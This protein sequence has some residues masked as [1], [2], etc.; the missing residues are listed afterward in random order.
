MGSVHGNVLV[1]LENEFQLAQQSQED[2]PDVPSYTTRSLNYGQL[3][4]IKGMTDLEFEWNHVPTLFVIDID[5][6]GRFSLE[7][8]KSFA[9][10]V[11]GKVPKHVP[12]DDFVGEVQA[13]CCFRMWSMCKET[14]D[15]AGAFTQWLSRLL[16]E[17]CPVHYRPLAAAPRLNRPRASAVFADS[18]P[19]AY[20]DLG[21]VRI[22]HE[23]LLLETNGMSYPALVNLLQT[24]AFEAD[25][26][27][28]YDESLDHLVPLCILLT[29]AKHFIES[30]WD[31]LRSLGI[32]E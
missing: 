16:C 11:A 18:D 13:R 8:L 1:H 7:E 9:F 12:P 26:L 2:R 31:M 23:L 14:A 25:L 10:W 22:V 4:R 28:I 27:D 32:L 6:D 17:C 5:K 19:I 30:Y 24:A 21:A 3:R 29:F 15:T 20:L